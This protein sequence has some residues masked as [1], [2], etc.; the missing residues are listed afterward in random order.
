[1]PVS[2]NYVSRELSRCLTLSIKWSLS[3]KCCDRNEFGSRSTYISTT[4]NNGA[5]PADSDGLRSLV[6]SE[7]RV[8]YKNSEDNN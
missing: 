6:A 7:A 4:L 1:M 2:R 5:N 3:L 8:K